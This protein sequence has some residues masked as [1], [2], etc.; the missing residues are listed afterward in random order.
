MYPITHEEFYKYY[1]DCPDFGWID[2]PDLGIV[3]YYRETKDGK[4]LVAIDD[5]DKYYCKYLYWRV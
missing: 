3:C 1:N 5:G 4:E 2:V